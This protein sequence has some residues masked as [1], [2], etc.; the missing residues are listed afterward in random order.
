MVHAVDT[1]AL[2]CR[3]AED[4]HACYHDAAC[5]SCNS[6]RGEGLPECKA[7]F[8][9]IKL[10]LLNNKSKRWRRAAAHAASAHKCSPCK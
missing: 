3:R 9:L 1:R 4:K 6:A 2:A 8:V 7:C 10:L 5:W